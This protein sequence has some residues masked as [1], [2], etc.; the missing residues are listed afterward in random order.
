MPRYTYKCLR[1]KETFEISHGMFFEQKVCIK[2]KAVDQLEK[3]PV[4]NIKTSKEQ[5]T[6]KK[7]GSI[8]DQYITDAKK[9]LTKQKQDLKTEMLDK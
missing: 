6:T 9:E 4:F 3:I 5:Q 8:V 7:V 2:C 1:C